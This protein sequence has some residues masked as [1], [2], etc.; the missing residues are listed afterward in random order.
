MMQGTA[1]FATEP[2]RWTAE[3]QVQLECGAQN[4]QLTFEAVA[5]ELVDA[6]AR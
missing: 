5:A 1:T 2:G 4:R 6:G 3:V